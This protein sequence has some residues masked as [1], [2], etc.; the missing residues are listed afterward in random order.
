MLSLGGGGLAVTVLDVGQGQSILLTS[1]GRTALV[2]CGGTGGEDPGDIAADYV[3]A[4]GRNTLDL[5]VLTHYHDDHACGVPELMERLTVSALAVPDVEP[6]N[7]LRVEILALAEEKGT[8]VIFI[9]ENTAVELGGA[10]LTL[11]APLG[12]GGGNEEGLSVLAT[13]GDFDAL[14]TGDMN[15]A[16]E[17]RLIKYGNLPDV[18]LLVVGHHGSKSSTSE[19]LLEAVMP[20]YAA[21]SVG[22]NSY[23]HPA[24]DTLE[25]LA[26][27]GCTVRRTDLQGTITVRAAD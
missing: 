24:P 12:T 25:R 7:P 16:V 14:I 17:Q 6:D 22:Y 13:L 4:M 8:E 23:G 20:E 11:Y 15:A 19:E 18:E 9:E 26:Q 10:S 27:A 3:Q 2:D 1:Q 5:L 21:I